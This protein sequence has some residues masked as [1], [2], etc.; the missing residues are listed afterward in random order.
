[1]AADLMHS[2]IRRQLSSSNEL[3][4]GLSVAGDA[5]GDQ[6]VAWKRCNTSGVCAL[7]A[8][9]RAARGRFGSVQPGSAIDASESP[10]IAVSPTG[11]SLLGWVQSGHVLAAA[12]AQRATRFGA[13]HRV[14]ATNFATELQ[15]AFGPTDT[16]L[17]TW[18][19][20]TLAQAVMGATYITP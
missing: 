14:S 2:P 6:A 4:A 20:G 19:Q 15:I 10:T 9:L 16:A 17:A 11:V 18:T 13:R 5:N 3:A 8:T 1:M 12:A 7:R